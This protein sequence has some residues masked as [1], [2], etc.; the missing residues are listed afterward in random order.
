MGAA[1]ALGVLFTS[2]S[3][4]KLQ[5]TMVPLNSV[6]NIVVVLAPSLCLHI[7]LPFQRTGHF[8]LVQPI[9]RWV[10][11][12]TFGAALEMV[13]WGVFHSLSGQWALLFGQW[14]KLIK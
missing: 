2:S 4:N 14:I 10:L 9:G 11:M 8:Q 7:S 13:L 12:V 3:S 5:A 1:V 6:N